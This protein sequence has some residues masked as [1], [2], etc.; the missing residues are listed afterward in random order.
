MT[1]SNNADSTA[2]QVIDFTAGYLN[3]T[4]DS[5]NIS[6]LLA[7]IGLITEQ[8]TIQYMMELEDNFGLTYENG[9]SN[10]LVTI[11]DAISFIQTKLSR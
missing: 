3:R 8:D 2:Q 1:D 6:T 5:I 11:G 4:T 10:E 7:D 9:D